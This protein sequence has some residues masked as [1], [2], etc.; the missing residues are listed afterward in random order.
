MP[1]RRACILHRETTPHTRFIS[2]LSQA[3]P[4]SKLYLPLGSH[5]QKYWIPCYILP[6]G[7][8]HVPI[9]SMI[10]SQTIQGIKIHKHNSITEF[11]N[12][13]NIMETGIDRIRTFCCLEFIFAI[14][15][16]VSLFP[17]AQKSTIGHQFYQ[18]MPHHSGR[19][20][21]LAKSTHQLNFCFSIVHT[22]SI[23]I[24]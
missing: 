14:D 6:G 3:P 15:W 8:V 11:N 9:W 19:K 24:I 10:I 2:V 17:N 7:L 18:Q 5:K 12:K 20:P 21:V 4:R 1:H 13:L 16:T 22:C 23:Y